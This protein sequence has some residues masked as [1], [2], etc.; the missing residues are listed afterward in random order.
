MSDNMQYWGFLSLGDLSQPDDLQFH[1]VSS[2][3]H[4]FTILF[5]FMVE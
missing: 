4:N 5:L 1:L 2:K 3:W